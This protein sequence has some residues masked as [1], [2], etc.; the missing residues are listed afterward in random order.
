MRLYFA[1]FS[2]LLLLLACTKDSQ[3]SILNWPEQAQPSIPVACDTCR[4]PVVM[5]HGFLASGDTYTKFHQLFTSN[6][7]KPEW[8]FA[9]DWNSLNFGADNSAA[10]DAFIDQVL[11]KTGA[12]QVRLMGHS[13]GG[14]LCYTY[15]SNATRAAKVDG[16]VHI[17]SNVQNG[18]PGPGATEPMLNLWSPGDKIVAGGNINGALNAEI[19]DKDHYEIATSKE[20]FLAVYRF[21]HN[22]DP[23]TLDITFEQIVCIGGRVLSF[24]ENQPLANAKVD[25]Y[26]VNPN[27]G[28]RLNTSPWE[29]WT[30]KADGSWGP[31]NVDANTTYEFVV[32]PPQGRVIH[33]F[34]EGFTH[35]NTLVYLRTLPSPFSPAGILLGGLPNSNNQ[36][37]LNFFSSSKA[38]IHMRDTLQV[39]GFTLSTSEYASPQ[40]TAISYFLYDDGDGQTSLN[41]VG[42]FGTF[43][44]LNGV[45]MFFQ[46][47]TPA[48]ITIQ[49]NE[50]R[51]NVRNIQSSNGIVV[52]VFD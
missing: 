32:T 19:P 9:F 37:V 7:Y 8:L 44:F 42:L 17:G 16:Y 50:R 20:S 36:S 30:S 21:F 49:F 22:E 40:K 1:L 11:A 6:G 23:S 31:T 5:V 35:L 48:P 33:Y 43:S 14:G 12:P 38:V 51:L 41:P 4:Y 28:E 25:I 39:N 24:G 18:P 29:T 3:S 34:R 2:A 26:P 13:A 10:L 47:Q 15:L 45:D 46:T 52:G 27:T